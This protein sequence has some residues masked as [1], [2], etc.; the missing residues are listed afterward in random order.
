M[1]RSLGLAKECS[2]VTA[3]CSSIER[4]GRRL[5]AVLASRV[6]PEPGGPERRRL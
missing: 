4:A 6:L 1:I 5:T 2:L 3:I